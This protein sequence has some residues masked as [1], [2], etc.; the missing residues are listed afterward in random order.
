VKSYTE[1]AKSDRKCE[2]GDAR[3]LMV[4]RLA[5]RVEID[6]EQQKA[7]TWLTW[8]GST[9]IKVGGLGSIIGS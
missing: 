2:Y 7:R 4:A 6:A 5:T 3:T 9:K 8:G 1:V